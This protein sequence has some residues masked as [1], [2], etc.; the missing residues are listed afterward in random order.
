MTAMV[1]NLLSVR[2]GAAPTAQYDGYTSCPV[3]T[4]RGKLIRAEFTYDKKLLESFPFD[5]RRERF[6]MYAAKAYML[7]RIYW[8][9]MLRSRI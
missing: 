2:A 5:Q 9:G 8:H 3:V 6:S 7:P 4:G 1:S